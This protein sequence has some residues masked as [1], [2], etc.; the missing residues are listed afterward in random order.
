MCLHTQ[1]RNSHWVCIQ[2]WVRGLVFDFEIKARALSGH[3]LWWKT[4]YYL[5]TIRRKQARKIVHPLQR[6]CV[7][8]NRCCCIWNEETSWSEKYNYLGLVCC[9]PLETMGAVEKWNLNVIENYEINTRLWCN[10][11]SI[12]A[13]GLQS[14]NVGWIEINGCYI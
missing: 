10:Y 12:G 1:S 13:K 8:G 5:R 7:M 14:L 2:P 6:V 9:D 3:I 11:W 4:P